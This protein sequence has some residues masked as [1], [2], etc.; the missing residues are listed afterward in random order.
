MKNYVPFQFQIS[1]RINTFAFCEKIKT[2]SFILHSSLIIKEIEQYL[3]HSSSRTQI[4][5][6]LLILLLKW[7][8]TIISNVKMQFC[9]RH[10][11]NNGIASL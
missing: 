1:I 4:K 9:Y 11:P 7:F 2:L 10:Y 3:F 8:L 6:P 5:R